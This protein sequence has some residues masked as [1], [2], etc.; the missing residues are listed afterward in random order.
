[1]E[2]PIVFVWQIVVIKMEDPVEGV[3]LNS[4][5]FVREETVNSA[6]RACREGNLA[7]LQV[8]YT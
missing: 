6:A 3:G 8:R 1:M 2:L 7:L 5:R 4:F